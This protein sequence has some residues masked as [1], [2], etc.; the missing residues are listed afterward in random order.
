M[1]GC[2]MY[3]SFVIYRSMHLDG[4]LAKS[5]KNDFDTVHLTFTDLNGNQFY[6]QF[7]IVSTGKG[8]VKM[9]QYFDNVSDDDNTVYF[10]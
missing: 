2:D 9:T 1:K 7:W 4:S 3:Q 6:V 5:D 10:D 8:I